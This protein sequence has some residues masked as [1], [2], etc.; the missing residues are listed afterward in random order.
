[1]LNLDMTFCSNTKCK[2]KKCERNQNN[3]EFDVIKI[4]NHPISIAD[5]S[6]DCKEVDDKRC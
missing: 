6:T 4:G 5:F 2:N 3:Y 1:M